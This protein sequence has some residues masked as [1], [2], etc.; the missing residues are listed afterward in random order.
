MDETSI[1]VVRVPLGVEAEKITNENIRLHTLA[2]FL[3]DDKTVH[4]PIP[5]GHP[6]I[7][8]H[9]SIQNEDEQVLAQCSDRTLR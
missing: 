6:D 2:Q 7:L 1:D 8:H 3:V 5:H 4:T 9:K